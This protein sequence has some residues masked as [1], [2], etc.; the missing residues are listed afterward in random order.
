METFLGDLGAVGYWVGSTLG[1]V[2]GLVL[3]VLMAWLIA[4]A[5][6]RVLGVPVGWFRSVLVA[7]LMVL[8]TN[9]VFDAVI[10]QVAGTDSSG[11]LSGVSAPAAMVLVLI[12]LLWI[13]G[14]GTALLM[15]LEMVIPTGVLPN[16]ILWFAGLRS[17]WARNRRYRQV[18][19]VFL[20]H[21][22]GANLR[23]FG[24]WSDHGEGSWAGTARALRAPLTRVAA[25]TAWAP[26]RPRSRSWSVA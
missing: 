3:L 5:V 17:T 10:T 25:P 16:P 13:F 20:R 24:R 9:V 6:R 4:T 19:G 2:F 23:G 8:S 26:G 15:I 22:L 14:L 21:G 7:L 1:A 18:V 12:A 11:A